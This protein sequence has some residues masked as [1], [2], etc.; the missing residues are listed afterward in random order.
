MVT[1]QLVINYWA[2]LIATVLYFVL[3]AF[4]YSPLMLGNQWKELTQFDE[5]SRKGRMARYGITFAVELVL[6]FILLHFIHYSTAYTGVGGPLGGI[7]TAFWAWLGFAATTYYI[8]N[9]FQGKSYQLFLIDSGYHLA[10]MLLSGIILGA[11]ST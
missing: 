8:N 4:W 5:K 6:V 11:W 2:V 7:Q 1:H 10:G 9:S 3:G